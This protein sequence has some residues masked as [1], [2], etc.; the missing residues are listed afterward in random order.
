MTRSWN[1]CV[2]LLLSLVPYLCPAIVP[3]LFQTGHFSVAP[4]PERRQLDPMKN[5]TDA[6][7][8]TI[9]SE[10]RVIALIGFSANQTRPSHN[11][12]QFLVAHGYRVIPVN[13]FLKGQVFEG[14]V[15]RGSLADCPVEVEMVDIFRR[16]D[17]VGP[18]VTDAITHLPNLRT[19]WMQI[20]VHDP[21]AAKR[22]LGHGLRVVW[23]KC[24]KIEHRRLSG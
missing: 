20:G 18:L 17:E 6:I 3:G 23:D 14:E 22:A 8:R 10:T 19:I 9:M 4:H 16:S 24:P 1:T 5:A 21:I 12:A 15:I 2:T 11:V 13:P 7:I